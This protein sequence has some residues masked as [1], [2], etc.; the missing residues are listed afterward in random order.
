MGFKW[1]QWKH[2]DLKSLV[3]ISAPPSTQLCE[4]TAVSSVIM[5]P[6]GAYGRRSKISKK[7]MEVAF[8]CNVL[9]RTG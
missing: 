4:L 6:G 7:K 3:L 1:T 5:P 2:P 9:C 8:K